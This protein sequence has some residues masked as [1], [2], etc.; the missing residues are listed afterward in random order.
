MSAPVMFPV[1]VSESKETAKAFP[2]VKA[3]A[4][5][6]APVVPD[7]VKLSVST[8]IPPLRADEPVTVRV[9][10]ADKF[11]IMFT[12]SALSVVTRVIY[13]LPAHPVLKLDEFH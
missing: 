10:E 2:V 13:E 11:L 6:A 9:P 8:V 7:I 5:E 1:W 3:P 4:I 12:A